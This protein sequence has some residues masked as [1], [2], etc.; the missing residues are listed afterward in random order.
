MTRL[1][2]HI[3]DLEAAKVAHS[4]RVRKIYENIVRDGYDRNAVSE[5]VRIRRRRAGD[6]LAFAKLSNA[7]ND[8]LAQLGDSRTYVPARAPAGAPAR[9]AR[10]PACEGAPAPARDSIK[11]RAYAL[12]EAARAAREA[13]P[14]ASAA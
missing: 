6:P 2:K 13:S 1:A 7:V 11:E 8:Y 14:E 4:E 10:T 3:E 5:V 9:D 12:S